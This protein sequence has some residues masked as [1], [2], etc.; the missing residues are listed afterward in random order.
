MDWLTFLSRVI[1]AI[2]WPGT[3]LVVIFLVRK[4]LPAI[5]RSLR[6]LKYKD[7][8]L[9][10]GVTVKAVANEVKEAIPAPT[11]PTLL[12]AQSNTDAL[13]R[14]Q[15]IADISPR[16]AILEAWLFVEAAA[17]DVIRKKN[18]AR[19]VRYPGPQRLRDNLQ[20]AEV[21]NER[22]LWVFE[23]LRRLRNEAVH[24]PDAQF[25]MELGTDYINAALRMAAYL[26]K[27]AN[28]S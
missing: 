14:L 9:E 7:L 19:A 6:R 25:T 15:S 20:Q 13:A 16:A 11:E 10:F 18:V 17:A 3:V 24:V 26:E 22:Q 4:E 2:A 27:A 23:S 28:A 5:V 8:E 1:D 21:L 12:P